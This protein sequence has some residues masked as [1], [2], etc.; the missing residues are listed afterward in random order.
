[1]LEYYS[2]YYLIGWYLVSCLWM[3]HL[4]LYKSFLISVFIPNNLKTVK[5]FISAKLFGTMFFFTIALCNLRATCVT[6]DYHYSFVGYEGGRTFVL[7]REVNNGTRI[8][9]LNFCLTSIH[10][11]L[12][13]YT[14]EEV[15]RVGSR[16]TRSECDVV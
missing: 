2:I 11:L 1:M 7:K 15:I 5:D 16:L 8:Y 9:Y 3:V 12:F 6:S 14:R 13:V 10:C 4:L